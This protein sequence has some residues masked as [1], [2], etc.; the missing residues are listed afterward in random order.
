MYS[1]IKILKAGNTKYLMTLCHCAIH[2]S[3]DLGVYNLTRVWVTMEKIK[4]ITG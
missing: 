4:A 1:R 2:T 3:D